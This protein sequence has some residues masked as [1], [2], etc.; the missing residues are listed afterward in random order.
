[1]NIL[2]VCSYRTRYLKEQKYVPGKKQEPAGPCEVAISKL[3]LYLGQSTKLLATDKVG[4]IYKKILGNKRLSLVLL[5]N[6]KVQLPQVQPA[7]NLI[8]KY[9]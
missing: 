1:M 6:E 7:L 5:M 4:S 3:L 8:E 9:I 2:D